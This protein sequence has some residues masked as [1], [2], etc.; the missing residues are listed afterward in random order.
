M[1]P[2]FFFLGRGCWGEVFFVFLPCS[3]SATAIS[4][5]QKCDQ[6]PRPKKNVCMLGNAPKAGHCGTKHTSDLPRGTPRSR[7]AHSKD[8]TLQLLLHGYVP[9]LHLDP[10]LA[11]LPHPNP[12]CYLTPTFCE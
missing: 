9:T 12:R 7:T 11:I 2:G 8:I 5:G 3:I 10:L 1:G 4:L 6:Q